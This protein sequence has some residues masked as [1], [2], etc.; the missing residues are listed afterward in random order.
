M[1]MK[2]LIENWK[3]ILLRKKMWRERKFLCVKV[4]EKSVYLEV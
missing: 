4:V 1:M 2:V 3:V